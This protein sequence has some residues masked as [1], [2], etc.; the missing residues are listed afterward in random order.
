[1]EI[2]GLGAVLGLAVAAACIA[3][4]RKG[5]RDG[6]A[7]GVAGKTGAAQSRPA[8]DEGEAA[9][10]RRY[11]AILSYDPFAPSREAAERPYGERV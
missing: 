6:G 10:M 2:L 7:K 9:M 8:A 3:C 5:V 4:Y 1:M 11:E